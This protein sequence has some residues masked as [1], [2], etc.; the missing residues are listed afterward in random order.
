MRRL[1]SLLS[2]L[3]CAS[4]LLLSAFFFLGSVSLGADEVSA[5]PVE[6]VRAPASDQTAPL[7]LT[8]SGPPT[9]TQRRPAWFTATVEPPTTTPPITYVWQAT[10]QPS[11]TAVVAARAHV[12]SFTW[13]VTGT[14][15]VTVTASNGVS[16][17]LQSAYTVTVAPPQPPLTLTVSGPPTVTQRRPAWF[18]ATVEPPTTTPPITYV[19]Q[20]TAQPSQTAV[21]A[22]RAHVISFTWDVTGTQRVTV[23][24]SNGVSAS[25]QS[26]R[27]I[28]VEQAPPSFLYLPL[29]LS[30]EASSST[31]DP[32]P[33]QNYA[34][35][36]VV[37]EH[38]QP[39]CPSAEEDPGFNINL[40][41][42]QPRPAYRCWFDSDGMDPAAPQFAYVYPNPH[43]PEISEAYQLYYNGEEAVSDH[44]PVPVSALGL[45]TAPGQVIH[46]PD[47]FGGSVVI[48]V[49]GY[50]ALVLYASEQSIALKYTREDGLVGYTTYID[51]ICVEPTLRALYEQADA[52][53]RTELPAVFGHQPVG[54][55][56]GDEIRVVVRDNGTLLDPRWLNDW[57]MHP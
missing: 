29:V 43:R 21:V 37:L 3:G 56:R 49:Q 20:A 33:G 45:P 17:P 6:P 32:I 18:T 15:R 46:A 2:T 1:Y 11:Q 34:K 44:V 22:A 50:K 27:T 12:I 8:V 52:A 41:D 57:W 28:T 48:D 38:S 39:P 26:A 24:A 35:I 31:C 4:V 25:L 47:R 10:A 51:G 30:Q 36:S 54:R 55:A 42:F 40:L 13:D 14:Q 53:G 9:V 7:T 23:T 16:A 5:H 19:W